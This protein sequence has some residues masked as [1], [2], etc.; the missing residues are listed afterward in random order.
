MKGILSLF[1]LFYAPL[2]AAYFDSDD[3][4]FL[5]SPEKTVEYCSKDS[6]SKSCLNSIV[7]KKDFLLSGEPNCEKIKEEGWRFFCL[8][9][10]NRNSGKYSQ[11]LDN[12]KKALLKDPANENI[13]LEIGII[14]LINSS[15]SKAAENFDAALA[16]DPYMEHALY[17][18]AAAYE[19][20][21][22]YKKAYKFIS[23]LEKTLNSSKTK[24]ETKLRII[25]NKKALIKEKE[26]KEEK[27]K[28]KNMALSCKEEYLK[29]PS[30]EEE[31]LYEK[32][33]TCLSYGDRTDFILLSHARICSKLGKYEEARNTLNLI[34]KF[35]YSNAKKNEALLVSAEL[36]LKEGQNTAAIKE[37]DKAFERGMDN[38]FWLI[39]YSKLAEENQDPLKALKA[40]EAIKEK[41]ETVKARIEYLKDKALSDDLI[42]SEL[43][44]RQVLPEGTSFLGPYEK[45]IFLS[46]RAAERNGA[47]DYI[48]KKY[49]GF[50]GLL[51]ENMENGEFVRKLTLKGFNLYMRDIS[52]KAVRFFEKK[53]ISLNEVFKLRTL[54]GENYFDK[55]GKLTDEGLIAYLESLTDENKK[56][57]LRSYET[58]PSQ[59]EK[60]KEQNDPAIQSLLSKGY[61]EISEGEYLWLMKETECPDTV[62]ISAPCDIKTIKNER[63]IKYFICY[64]E[65]LCSKEALILSGYIGSYRQDGGKQFSEKQTNSGFF[66]SPGSIKRK[67]CYKGRIWN[68]LD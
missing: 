10:K 25:R 46:I 16:A 35:G 62:L 26:E 61:M 66:G 36:Y 39:K 6:S 23:Y 45:K 33:K 49:M 51:T 3:S 12:C 47:A 38:P 4:K 18:S 27:K 68:G 19:R 42:L 56:N 34:E 67:F 64:K 29:I 58:P 1:I 21:G 28:K 32:G 48:R 43:I 60:P 11:A 9:K 53:G 52:Q 57:W 24:N 59:A 50:A 8:C 2:K 55:T 40:L 41:D 44:L 37:L 54:S 30:H 14:Y 13:H 7:T 63:N 65:G 5:S 20:I 17:L 31:K 22:D 15:Y